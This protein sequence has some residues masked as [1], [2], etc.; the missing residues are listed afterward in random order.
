MLKLKHKL[1]KNLIIIW[2]LALFATIAIGLTTYYYEKNIAFKK[3]DEELKRITDIVSFRTYVWHSGRE[4]ELLMFS[5]SPFFIDAISS[6]F[7]NPN[8]EILEKNISKR[9]D[10]INKKNDYS[11]I[12]I[13]DISGKILYCNGDSVTELNETTI[14]YIKK[15]LETKESL[16]TNF[17]N[18]KMHEIIHIDYISPLI[19]DDLT[20]GFLIFRAETQR[21]IPFVLKAYSNQLTNSFNYLFRVD[22]NNVIFFNSEKQDIEIDKLE[23]TLIENLDTLSILES[24]GLKIDNHIYRINPVYSTDW[25]ILNTMSNDSLISYFRTSPNRILLYLSIVFFIVTLLLTFYYHTITKNEYAKKLIKEKG[26]S[27]YYKEFY[28]VLQSI[29]NGVITIDEHRIIKTVNNLASELLLM[30]KE[31]LLNKSSSLLKEINPDI[32]T[33]IEE[34]F[35]TGNIEETTIDNTN[36]QDK[37]NSNII[38]SIKAS[39]IYGN[40][41]KIIGVALILSDKTKDV[42]ILDK[43]KKSE[44][45]YRML[46]SNMTQGFAL[47]DIILDTNNSPVNYRYLNVNQAFEK[48]T[49]FTEKN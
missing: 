32:E 33:I 15:S 18:C 9:I 29:A 16:H 41:N 2:I 21:T 20:I 46:F 36:N 39:P 8:D 47:H 45:Q 22:N 49:G 4:S 30:P 35:K 25:F 28:S 42:K 1:K 19:E 27:K 38:L 44:E 3:N 17:Y 11:S 43:I 13:T 14:S 10:L 24:Y 7:S 34:V 5:Q 40:S 26:A 31:E 23:K 6:W 48:M 37:I 12:L